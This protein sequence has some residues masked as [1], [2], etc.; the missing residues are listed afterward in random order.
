MADK[1]NHGWDLTEALQNVRALI[2]QK[3]TT[4]LRVKDDK[5]LCHVLNRLQDRAEEDREPFEKTWFMNVSH[6]L[7]H[8]Y[9]SWARKG[10]DYRTEAAPTWRV[11]HKVNLVAAALQRKLAKIMRL[12]PK[13]MVIPRNTENAK[14][15]AAEL[16]GNVLE[17]KFEEHE[18]QRRQQ[19][20]IIKADLY[21]RAYL[22]TWWNPFL[23]QQSSDETDEGEREFIYDGDVDFAVDDPLTFYYDPSADYLSDAQWCMSVHLKTRGWAMDHFPDIAKPL[24]ETHGDAQGE[25]AAGYWDRL[26]DYIQGTDKKASEYVMVREYWQR[27]DSRS[28]DK[29][30]RGGFYCIVIDDVIAKEPTPFPYESG[31][32]PWVEMT[33]AFLQGVSKHGP[34]NVF[35]WLPMQRMYNELIS[36]QKENLDMFSKPKWVVPRGCNIDEDA[37]TTEPAEIIMY[38]RTGDGS[39]P[40]PVTPK[41]PNPQSY[42]TLLSITRG[43]FEDAAGIHEVSRGIS[44][45]ANM[46]AEGIELLLQADDTMMRPQSDEYRNALRKVMI[47]ILKHYKQYSRDDKREMVLYK[48]SQTFEQFSFSGVDIDF[49]DVRIEPNSMTPT[50]PV[51]MRGQIAQFAQIGLFGPYESPEHYAMAKKVIRMLQWGD[52]SI[53]FDEANK[54]DERAEWE[55][56]QLDKIEEMLP[57]TDEQGQPAVDEITGE[58]KQAP[59]GGIPPNPFDDDDQHIK[60][61]ELRQKDLSFNK[62]H[63]AAQRAHLEHVEAHK[64]AKVL[65]TLEPEQ[66]QQEL[67]MKGAITPTSPQQAAMAMPDKHI[68]IASGEP[69]GPDD[70]GA[71]M[72][73]QPDA[74]PP[75]PP[76]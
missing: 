9:V 71:P 52:M 4:A 13:P 12:T 62:L 6:A 66:I 2:G 37:I 32:L 54:D 30:K 18:T 43:D 44:P 74:G 1:K 26:V 59:G 51:A 33:D 8:Q 27:P 39:E 73:P 50:N 11:R 48:G 29:W 16:C 42:S 65:K 15:K 34:T 67:V 75:G 61:H 69:M 22:K 41:D 25:K 21:G 14:K 7:G 24:M 70:G 47:M 45:G 68:Q 5:S 20:W 55:N 58:P 64:Q 28:K 31:E 40:K 10:A 3:S 76:V 56:D 57:L 60:K 49:A 19:E 23:G 35:Q 53:A 17:A 38:N 36:I 46:P 63:P 72:A